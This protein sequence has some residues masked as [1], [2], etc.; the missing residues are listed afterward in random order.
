LF[1]RDQDDEETINTLWVART[2]GEVEQVIDLKSENIVH[3]ARFS[4]ESNRVAF[5]SVEQRASAPGWQ[6]NNDLKVIGL[7]SS[8]F[9][10]NPVTFLEANA[11]GVY[12]WWG[13]EFYWSPDGRQLAYARP[14]SVGMFAL[15]EGILNPLLEL[16]PLQTKQ[17]WA[18]VPGISWG[19][20]G[21]VLYTVTHVSPPGAPLP[22]ES[23]QFDLV[24]INTD[25]GAPIT[26]ASSVGMFSYPVASPILA[27]DK[28]AGGEIPYQVA[29]LQAVFPNQSDAS[30][31][32]L[33]VMDRD[34]SN[35]RILF[36]QEGAQGLDP[37]RVVWSPA[38]VL[39]DGS[40]VIA[41]IYQNNI[42]LV[43]LVDGSVQQITGDG[44]AS[45]I[46]WR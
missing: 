22:E 3:F 29:Y 5:S 19:P 34:G 35:R 33:V 13:T 2:D 28:G 10:A 16:L 46:D 11:G 21:S 9:V 40:H 15:D 39:E 6:A 43:S 26:L 4:P 17:D 41:I 20:D 31:Y 14:D 23:P 30:R 7:S 25:G 42:W 12:G 8:G 27:T 18:W 44:L 24:G 38:P 45:R 36:P 37:Q 1:T 32:R